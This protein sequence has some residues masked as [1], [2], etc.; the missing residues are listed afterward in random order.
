MTKIVYRQGWYGL[1]RADWRIA[2]Q[3]SNEVAYHIGVNITEFQGRFNN[4][5]ANTSNLRIGGRRTLRGIGQLSIQWMEFRDQ[6]YRPFD[7][8]RSGIRRNDI[9][10][11][12]SSGVP[13]DSCLYRE[14]GLWYVRNESSY[15]Y[16]N[17]DGNRLGMKFEQGFGDLNGH[18]LLARVDVERIAARFTRRPTEIDPHAA[19]TTTGLSLTDRVTFGKIDLQGSLRAEYSTL[20]VSPDTVEFDDNLMAG[21]SVSASY[22]LTDS[23][24]LFGLASSSWRYPGLDET[25]GY[26]SVRT[27]DRWMDVLPVPDYTTFYHGNPAL[28]PVKTDYVGAGVA[29]S[30]PEYR[31][32][33]VQSG[34]RQWRD[35]ILPY[36]MTPNVWTR[37]NYENYNSLES[38]VYAWTP[39][40][41]P[42]SA[43]ASFTYAEPITPAA[44]VPEIFGWASLRFMDHYYW[45]QLRIRATVTAYFWDEYQT[46]TYYQES[47]WTYDAI[48]NFKVFNFEA[49]YGTRN[50]MGAPYQFI[51][52]FPNMHRDEIWGVRWVLFD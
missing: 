46:A 11:S 13:G 34:I 12:L 19:R 7:A 18:D 42:V 35:Q 43:A 33:H 36:A 52:S 9:D 6:W 40:Y 30:W 49:Y 50:V 32:I 5:A 2:H 39:L 37:D 29:M 20:K 23:L 1:G 38:T 15:R 28:K 21:G 27:P 16:G 26:W 51:P 48:L 17:E 8:G 14:L 45:N 22:S 24:R 41:G 31:Q 44:P 3:V 4:T 10:V 47:A 25:T